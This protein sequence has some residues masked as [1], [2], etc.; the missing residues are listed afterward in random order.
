MHDTPAPTVTPSGGAVYQ[1]GW[2]TP[3]NVMVSHKRDWG[4]RLPIFL[5]G[6]RVSTHD[7]MDLTT[8]NLALRREVRLPCNLLFGAPPTR[9]PHHQPRS[10]SRGSITWHPQLCRQHLKLASDWM[11]TCYNFLANCTGY[12]GW[13]SVAVSP[14]PHQGEVTQASTLMGG[15]PEST[16]WCTCYKALCTCTMLSSSFVIV[17]CSSANIK[18]I[19]AILLAL[20]SLRHIVM[21][22]CTQAL[23]RFL[24]ES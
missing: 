2:A 9:A 8:A 7:T 12:H 22:L 11:K 14:N 17:A 13:P 15:P 6:Y 19:S 4:L 1:N 23:K 16:M 24:S 5:F 21:T 18:V 10:K 20:S 3:G